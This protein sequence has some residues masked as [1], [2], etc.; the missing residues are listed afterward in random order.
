MQHSLSSVSSPIALVI[1]F[2]FLTIFSAHAEQRFFYSYSKDPNAK[3]S[4][5]DGNVSPYSPSM[6]VNP[7]NVY[8]QWNTT[9]P[10]L[11][12]Q[13][14]D[15]HVMYPFLFEKRRNLYDIRL[16]AVQLG[17]DTFRRAFFMTRIPK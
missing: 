13:G 6:L 5:D 2:A 1:S 14:A 15:D 8:I 4:L 3:Y 12:L 10:I 7:M 9:R 11:G 16:K 17:M